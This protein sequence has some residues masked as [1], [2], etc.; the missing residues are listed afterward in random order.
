L[1]LDAWFGGDHPEACSDAGLLPGAPGNTG[2][3]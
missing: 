3:R 2:L 1:L